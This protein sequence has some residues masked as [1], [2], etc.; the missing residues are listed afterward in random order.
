MPQSYRY[1]RL[2]K[3]KLGVSA[4]QFK[5][6]WLNGCAESDRRALASASM[7][8]IVKDICTGE[9]AMG[10]AEPPFD[11]MLSLYFDSLSDA[12][13]ACAGNK[14]A[15]LFQGDSEYLDASH[16][17]ISEIYQMGQKPDAEAILAAPQRLKII[18]T[19][20]H[21]N[22]L[23]L[24][25]FKDYWLKNHSKLE[26]VVIEKSP[27]LRIIA[28]FAVPGGLDGRAVPFDG[29]AELYFRS[30][31]DIRAMFASPIPAM[32]REDEAN[33]VQMDAP[34]IRF[35][36]DEYITAERKN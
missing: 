21:R 11:G 24:Q 20:F 35:I 15:A 16:E 10:G 8:R 7:R 22:D 27:A 5:S 25:Q 14:I 12:Q 26:D 33:F 18:R 3:R 23:S 19:V 29:T 6:Y 9:V 13:T 30:V 1:S 2:V 36:V 34:A 31:Q 32:M 28:T 4:D 17:M